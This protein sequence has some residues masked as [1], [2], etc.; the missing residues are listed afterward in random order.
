[1]YLAGY[2]NPSIIVVNINNVNLNIID[3][4]KYIFISGIVYYGFEDLTKIVNILNCAFGKKVLKS[5]QNQL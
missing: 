2:L 1:M 5:R 3:S 4:I